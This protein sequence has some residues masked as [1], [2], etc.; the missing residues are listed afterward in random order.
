MR[1]RI[2]FVASLFLMVAL[3]PPAHAQNTD[4]PASPP[5]EVPAPAEVPPPAAVPPPAVPPPTAAAVPPPAAAVIPPSHVAPAA[6]LPP[7]VAAP[8]PTR[9]RSYLGRLVLADLAWVGVGL[10]ALNAESGELLAL[11]AVGYVAAAPAVHIATGEPGHAGWSLA[12]RVA[13]AVGG[14][15]VGYAATDRCSDDFGYEEDYEDCEDWGQALATVGGILIGGSVAVV[16]DYAL[17]SR[18]TVVEAPSWTP[19]VSTHGN[20]VSIGLARRF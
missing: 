4:A 13:G 1:T 16:L 3:A 19:T 2:A 14:G 5:T 11:S 20:G 6:P 15:V 12:L 9:G 7:M 8:V 17:L 10:L 18:R